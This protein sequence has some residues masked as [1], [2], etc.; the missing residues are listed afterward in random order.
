MNEIVEILVDQPIN[1]ST[2]IE[3]L[4]KR[5]GCEYDIQRITDLRNQSLDQ[6]SNSI[7]QKIQSTQNFYAY[8]YD[9]LANIQE[10]VQ[11]NRDKADLTFEKTNQELDHEL[12]KINN[13]DLETELNRDIST[14]KTNMDT[15]TNHI[16]FTQRKIEAINTQIENSFE[17]MERYK[18]T[19]RE[20]QSKIKKKQK[21][22]NLFLKKMKNRITESVQTQKKYSKHVIS[23]KIDLLRR[24]IIVDQQR[25]QELSKQLEDIQRQRDTK[26]ISMT[27]L[28]A[29]KSE[30]KHYK[31]KTQ[32]KKE[33]FQ[34][35]KPPISEIEKVRT[36]KQ[37][38]KSKLH[39]ETTKYK[40]LL[41]K[42]SNLLNESIKIKNL[43]KEEDFKYEKA[44]DETFVIPPTTKKTVQTIVNDP[45]DFPQQNYFDGVEFLQD[46]LQ[47]DTNSLTNMINQVK[48]EI[49]NLK[50]EINKESCKIIESKRNNDIPTPRIS[51]ELYQLQIEEIEWKINSRKKSVLEKRER[52][53]ELRRKVKKAELSL[54]TYKSCNNQFSTKMLLDMIN[55]IEN[56]LEQWRNISHNSISTLLVEYNNNLFLQ[57]INFI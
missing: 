19:S 18:A 47:K 7:E 49:N 31:S 6:I 40:K 30:V 53:N 26:S 45:S 8:L 52:V 29:I 15:A 36:E 39:E 17:D 34:K 4:S 11:Y 38:V 56:D 24:S 2:K 35:F 42:V 44:V 28:I 5:I 23:K 20:L 37:Q 51:P 32:I 12:Q 22:I 9:I 13:E 57:E 27:E 55:Q 48:L 16:F 3:K 41:K 46:E 1:I 21:E 43:I 25:I 14:Y 10:D 50:I 33:K 54:L